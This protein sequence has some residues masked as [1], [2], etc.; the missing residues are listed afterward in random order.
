[1]CFQDLSFKLNV[2]FM[3]FQ[4]SNKNKNFKTICDG[5]SY[6]EVQTKH[7]GFFYLHCFFYQLE[8]NQ[9]FM[10][11][12]L[13]SLVEKQPRALFCKKIFSQKFCKIHRKKP[14]P[15]S[16]L[17]KASGLKPATLVRRR[18]FSVNFAKCLRRSFLQS[19]S[20][21]L[22]LTCCYEL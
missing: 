5:C 9:F 12:N 18:C 19:T 17:N 15:E 3:F 7:C 16:F 4:D 8:E 2:F 13:L 22:L 11:M 6:I 21:R 10:Q 20:Q 14:V 1:M